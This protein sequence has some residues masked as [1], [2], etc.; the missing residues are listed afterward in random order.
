MISCGHYFHKSCFEKS[1]SLNNFKCPLCE[2]LHN[3]LIP[4]LINFYNRD[5]FL[6]PQL[7]AK[8]IFD[9][10]NFKYDNIIIKQEFQKIVFD[11]I[12]ENIKLS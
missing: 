11:F 1:N 9:N 8:D 2:K 10:K 4:P 6:K 3:I 12:E 7:K 5:N